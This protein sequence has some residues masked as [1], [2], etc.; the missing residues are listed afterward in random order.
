[1]QKVPPIRVG[2]LTYDPSRELGRGVGGSS[3]RV[4]AGEVQGG[5]QCAVKVVRKDSG[6]VGSGSESAARAFRLGRERCTSLLPTFSVDAVRAC[7]S[8]AVSRSTF[9][10][11]EQEWESLLGEYIFHTTD[12]IGRPTLR[13]KRSTRVGGGVRSAR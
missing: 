6:V 2:R 5:R 10:L 12:A 11:R 9:Y 13:A 4:Y 1:M 3:T 8:Y 7:A